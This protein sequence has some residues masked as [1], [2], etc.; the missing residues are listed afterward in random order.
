M[1]KVY[2]INIYINN[3]KCT[4]LCGFKFDHSSE[5]YVYMFTSNMMMF[6]LLSKLNNLHFVFSF[7][8]QPLF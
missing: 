8:S 6:A 2:N 1:Y 5:V 7:N 4:D 3:C